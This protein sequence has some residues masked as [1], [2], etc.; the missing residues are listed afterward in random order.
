MT[1]QTFSID[2]EQA[3]AIADKIDRLIKSVSSRRADKWMAEQRAAH[4][5]SSP[6]CIAWQHSWTQFQRQEQASLE[7]AFVKALADTAVPGIDFDVEA[8]WAWID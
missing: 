5:P 8:G 6:L 3:M 4:D 1:I 7:Y 2:G